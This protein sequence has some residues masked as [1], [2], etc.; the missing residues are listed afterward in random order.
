[1]ATYHPG[2]LETQA[3][4]YL[5]GA[6]AAGFFNPQGSSQINSA[7]RA[8][9]L[10]NADNARR[11]SALLSRLMGLDPNQAAVAA[12]NQD[13]QN[14]GATQSALNQSSL[15]QQLGNQNYFR[16]LFGQQLGNEQQR[17]NMLYQHQLN[18]PGFGQIAGGIL[19]QGIGA[20]TGGLGSR[21][22]AGRP[23]GGGGGGLPSMNYLTDAA[24]INSQPDY[25]YL[26]PQVQ[27]QQY[28]QPQQY[29]TR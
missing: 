19:G 22:G 9:A 10:R 1:M 8:N 16:G 15:Q 23:G 24:G 26:L 14:T 11:R 5:Q 7:V 3:G 12:V 28:Y 21:L 27:Q 4:G 18:Q 20:F 25:S 13:A 6:N 2:A 29:A 17:Q